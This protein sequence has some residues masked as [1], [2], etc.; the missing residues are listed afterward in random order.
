MLSS[1][2]QRREET[3][4]VAQAIQEGHGE[5]VAREFAI[6][7]IQPV[8]DQ[9][10]AAAA[11]AREKAPT[12][13]E[14]MDAYGALARIQ[15]R[16]PVVHLISR[17]KRDDPV[18]A[19]SIL[20]RHDEMTRNTEWCRLLDI[21]VQN[22]AEGYLRDARG[23]LEQSAQAAR[24]LV[25]ASSQRGT[26]GRRMAVTHPPDTQLTPWSGANWTGEHQQR[27]PG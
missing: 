26:P 1:S 21:E 25:Q 7:Q 13:R 15:S 14:V 3:R 17:M 20:D 5:Q 18:H 19:R 24:S 12:A 4:A 16:N 8:Y 23:L 10:R 27:A 2:A 22:Y 11:A 6:A 9:A